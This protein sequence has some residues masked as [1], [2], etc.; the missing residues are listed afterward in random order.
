MKT[1]AH[2]LIGIIHYTVTN[3]K[4]EVLLST[5][6][7]EPMPYLHGARNAL[8]GLEDGLV[9]LKV[10]DTKK[11]TVSPEQGYGVRD[12]EKFIMTFPRIQFKIEDQDKMRPG[13]CFLAE[14]HDTRTNHAAWV[15]DYDED[16]ITV[17]M[18]HPL[19]GQVLNF[20]VEVVGIREPSGPELIFGH[21]HTI[22]GV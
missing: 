9:G 3:S 4:G 11:I 17:D 7:G 15:V 12:D 16:N 1:L 2:G 10:G 19:S 14:N 13:A 21:P 22:Y 20:D 8:R 6:D 18:Q 5:F